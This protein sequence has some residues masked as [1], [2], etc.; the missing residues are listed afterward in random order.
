M[1]H[2]YK[3]VVVNGVT[4]TTCSCGWKNKAASSLIA[5]LDAIEH[6]FIDNPASGTTEVRLVRVERIVSALA[7]AHRA[8][9]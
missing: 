5:T 1:T 4:E 9:L 2:E 7:G 8:Q 6:E 3:H